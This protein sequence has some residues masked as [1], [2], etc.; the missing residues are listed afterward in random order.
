MA[1]RLDSLRQVDVQVADL[2]GTLLGM[3]SPSNLVWIDRDAAGYGWSTDSGPG[4]GMDLPS[5]VSHEL[6]HKLGLEHSDGH[7]VMAPTLTLGTQPLPWS[8][9]AAECFLPDTADPATPLALEP[10]LADEALSLWALT[11]SSRPLESAASAAARS[12][13]V[14]EMMAT[15][16][17]QG[18]RLDALP[19]TDEDVDEEQTEDDLQDELLPSLI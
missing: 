13:R 1:S 6:G 11:D 2:S 16:W 9:F 19:D 15:E 8:T 10:R 18:P 12:D 14:F 3:A 4:G 5:A 17:N 7:D